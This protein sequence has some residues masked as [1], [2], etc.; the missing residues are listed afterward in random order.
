MNFIC[1]DGRH[2]VSKINRT[3][4]MYVNSD[5]RELEM[6]HYGEVKVK[7]DRQRKGIDKTNISKQTSIF[8]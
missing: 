1:E 4:S 8:L 7:T 3:A 5:R 2:A 6:H